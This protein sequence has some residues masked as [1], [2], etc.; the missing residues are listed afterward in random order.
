MVQRLHSEKMLNTYCGMIP[1]VPH[2]MQLEGAAKHAKFYAGIRSLVQ[3][4][5][6]QP[7]SVCID[8]QSSPTQ[9]H[10]NLTLKRRRTYCERHTPRDYFTELRLIDPKCNGILF[11]SKSNRFREKSV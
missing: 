5:L 8:N 11:H 7:S 3:R 2:R 6:M 9:K 1:A 4:I 10:T